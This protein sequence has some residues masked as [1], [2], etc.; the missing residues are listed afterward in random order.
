VDD[1]Q[2]D[3]CITG[4]GY[5]GLTAAWRLKERGKSVVLLEARDRVGGRTWTEHLSDGTWIDRGGAWIGYGQDR[6]YALA[7]ELGVETYPAFKDGD[8]MFVVDG[9]AHRYHGVIPGGINLLSVACFGLAL[10]RIDRMA[11]EVPLDAPWTAKRALEWDRQTVGQWIASSF[12]VPTKRARD[13]MTSLM[14]DSA[15]ASPDELSLLGMLFFSHALGGYEKAADTREGTQKDRVVGGMQTMARL[16]AGRIGDGLRLSA[17]VRRIAQDARGV[18]VTADGVRVR[19][20]RVVVAMSPF[21]SARISYEPGL[22]DERTLLAQRMPHGCI[23]KVNVVYDDAF[24]RRDGLCGQTAGIGL[25]VVLTLDGCGVQTSP[26]ILVALLA[27]PLAQVLTRRSAAERKQ[28]VL[29]DLV[30]RFGPKA[31]SPVA[32]IEQ[33]WTAEE[34]SQ[35]YIGHFPPGMLTSVG[36]ALREPVGRIHWAGTET[37][38]TSYLAIDGAVRSG[39]R[40]TQEVLAAGD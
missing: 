8:N 3:V 22:P 36:H 25:P 23:I 24:W 17:P 7:K 10:K 13:V 14:T 33:D 2:T 5:A 15:G 11:L 35:G 4:G 34:Y 18:T 1:I 31:K 6:M 16:M 28:V 20:R 39:E 40:V 30:N 37:A 38:T 19:A 32:Y 12:N 29:D 21:L 26:G 27:G 9:K